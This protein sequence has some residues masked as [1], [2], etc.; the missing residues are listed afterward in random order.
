MPNLIK[1]WDLPSSSFNKLLNFML[2][3]FAATVIK[4]TTKPFNFI[5]SILSKGTYI[6]KLCTTFKRYKLFRQ[7]KVSL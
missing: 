4:Q 6:V 3:Q 5:K 2:T 1:Q 7:V